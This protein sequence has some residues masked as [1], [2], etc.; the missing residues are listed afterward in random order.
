MKINDVFRSVFDAEK[1][2]S[3]LQRHI[4]LVERMKQTEHSIFDKWSEA[5]PAHIHLH[6]STHL[7]D[8]NDEGLLRVNFNEKVCRLCA[9][10]P[11]ASP[12]N[13]LFLFCIFHIS[14]EYRSVA[15]SNLSVDVIRYET[16][17]FIKLF[18]LYACSV[19]HFPIWLNLRSVQFTRTTQLLTFIFLHSLG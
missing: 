7:L 4:Q 6:T 9:A 18:H 16:T 14:L 3:V 5:I 11:T 1:G 2:Q 8:K 19:S 12:A 15:I 17:L 13:T 10:R